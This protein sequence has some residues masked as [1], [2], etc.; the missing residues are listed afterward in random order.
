MHKI[1]IDKGDYNFI[2]QLPQVIYSSLISVIINIVTK[3][4][5]L[6]EKD[7]ISLKQKNKATLEQK[8]N[9][10]LKK[11]K[12]KFII[13][14]LLS[15]LLLITFW[16]FITCFCGVYKNTQVHLINDSIIGFVMFLIYPL[17]IYLIPGIFRIN[18]LR[19][20]KKDKNYLYKISKLIQMI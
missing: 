10:L 7:I 12:I 14:F 15:F 13:F 2:Y 20:V 1:Y 5:A 11:L 17:V 16:T 18:A 6:S 3:K 19:S 4:L 8:K 9:N